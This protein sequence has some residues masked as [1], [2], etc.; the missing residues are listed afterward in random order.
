MFQA[1]G[2]VAGAIFGT[3]SKVILPQAYIKLRPPLSSVWN[4]RP[5]L[6]IRCIH[7]LCR[8]HDGLLSFLPCTGFSCAGKASAAAAFTLGSELSCIQMGPET[9]SDD[10][11][12]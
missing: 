5:S 7:L 1:V 8:R 4:W 3:L 10:L 12:G 11:G 2:G 9:R 6:H